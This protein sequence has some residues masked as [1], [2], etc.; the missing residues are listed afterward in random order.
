MLCL[1]AV[2]PCKTVT[3]YSW[4]WHGF[5][6]VIFLFHSKRTRLTVDKEGITSIWMSMVELRVLRLKN[7]HFRVF[8]MPLII[9]ESESRYV[10]RTI[11]DTHQTIPWFLLSPCIS[12]QVKLYILQ[13]ESTLWAT[14]WGH[15][16]GWN[17]DYFM[18]DIRVFSRH[19]YLLRMVM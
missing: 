8:S 3:D 6:V 10:A 7:P 14:A 15:N 9:L 11:T 17:E 13:K 16:N 18:S 2:A 12:T 5:S 4:L 19:R 1:F